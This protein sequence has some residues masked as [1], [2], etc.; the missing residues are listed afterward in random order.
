M[1]DS[2]TSVY[3]SRITSDALDL[4]EDSGLQ[5]SPVSQTCQDA[6]SFPPLPHS[7]TSTTPPIKGINAWIFPQSQNNHLSLVP[8]TLRKG[9]FHTPINTSLTRQTTYLSDQLMRIEYYNQYDPPKTMMTNI[10]RRNTKCE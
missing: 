4:T 5:P 6:P 1:Y 2:D 9:M 3:M 7:A 8:L 10:L